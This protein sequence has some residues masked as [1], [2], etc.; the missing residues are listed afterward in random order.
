M[1]CL[2]IWLPV[3]KFS[4]RMPRFLSSPGSHRSQNLHKQFVV[5]VWHIT[6]GY[7]SSVSRTPQLSWGPSIVHT[8]AYILAVRVGAR[9]VLASYASCTLLVLTKRQNRLVFWWSNH[10]FSLTLKVLLAITLILLQQDVFIH[11]RRTRP[12]RRI[13]T[14]RSHLKTR[15]EKQD[16]TYSC[17]TR[18]QD[19]QDAFDRHARLSRR[20][21]KN[22]TR[23]IHT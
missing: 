15:S 9:P 22:T 3:S 21:R 7:W 4:L 16:K 6:R 17:I 20:V 13:R 18:R 5:T 10:Y 12:T 23:R 14:A 2:T 8:L 1:P 11:N 19:L